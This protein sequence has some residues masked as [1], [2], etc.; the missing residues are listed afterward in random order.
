MHP[1]DGTIQPHPKAI[2]PARDR[3]QSRVLVCAMLPVICWADTVAVRYALNAGRSGRGYLALSVA[4]SMFFGLLAWRLKSATAEAA[5]CGGMICVAVTVLSGRPEGLSPF[6]SGLAPLI[7]LFV[8]T[9]ETT[10][11]GRD[12]KAVLGIAETREGRNAAQIVAN[13]G[14]AVIPNAFFL[15]AFGS[16]VRH[17]LQWPHILTL[18]SVPMLAALAEATADTVS[19][20]IGKAFGGHPRLVTTLR[21]ASPEQMAPSAPWAHAQA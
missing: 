18:L 4:I 16:G 8:L 2:S 21:R 10:R 20:E 6:H 15:L 9:G 5:M 1:L 11:L 3:L 17:G 14:T 19:S 13:I 12:R 7:L